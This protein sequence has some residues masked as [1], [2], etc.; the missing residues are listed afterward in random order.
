MA[1]DIE[2]MRCYYKALRLITQTP[3][4]LNIIILCKVL[5]FESLLW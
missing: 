4:G 2:Q 3:I 5:R 1:Q